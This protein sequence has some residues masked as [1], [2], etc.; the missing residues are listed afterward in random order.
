MAEPFHMYDTLMLYTLYI[1][2]FYFSTVPIY[3]WKN[4]I[5][6]RQIS[7]WRDVY[8]LWA[9]ENCMVK[10]QWDTTSPPLEWL[11]LPRATI[12][13]Q[14]DGEEQELLRRCTV[15]KPFWKTDGRFPNKLKL[16]PPYDP[17]IPFLSIS[18]RKVKMCV[19]IMIC[20]CMFTA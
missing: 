5:Y 3:S 15:L 4:K 16:Y 8:H 12:Q 7:T 2:Q 11:K 20:V 17:A 9:L 19:Y 14:Q 6:G 13:F 1:L 18:P 10:P